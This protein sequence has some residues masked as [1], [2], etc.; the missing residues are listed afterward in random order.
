MIKINSR[1]T[2]ES[3]VAVERRKT[4]D[5]NRLK[6]VVSGDIAIVPLLR[7]DGKLATIDAADVPLIQTRT[8]QVVETAVISPARYGDPQTT[9]GRV[10][11]GITD[12]AVK[13][14]HRDED[15][16]NNRRAN[17][18]VGGCSQQMQHRGLRSDNTSGFK[19]VH[20][21][22]DTGK[23]RA[24]LGVAPGK[25]LRLGNFSTAENAA[26][27]YDRAAAAHF[28]E[29]AILNFPAAEETCPAAG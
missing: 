15:P 7:G 12:P 11:L 3:R 22:P 19:G 9:M 20:L 26:R 25:S 18:M 14:L 4:S 16:L 1:R 21:R 17:L 24:T 8:W 5:R 29:F 6:I 10:I 23:W 13:V 2:Q 28:G 27:A